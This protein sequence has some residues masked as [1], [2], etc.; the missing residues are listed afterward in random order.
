MRKKPCRYLWSESYG[1][2]LYKQSNSEVWRAFNGGADQP[3]RGNKRST[4]EEVP[5]AFCTGSPVPGFGHHIDR[6]SGRLIGTTVESAPHFAVAL[7]VELAPVALAPQI[8]ARLLSHL[9]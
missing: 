7:L 4:E 9:Q 5:Q 2:K 1:S 3:A 6:S 8:P